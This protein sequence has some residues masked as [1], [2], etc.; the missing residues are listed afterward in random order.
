MG[1]T[2]KWQPVAVV[3]RG[4]ESVLAKVD[5]TL[6]TLWQ[7]QNIRPV[8]PASEVE[9]LRRV[10]LDLAGRTPTVTEVRHYLKDTDVNRY[11]K[12]VAKLL[13]SAD[14]ASHLATTWRTILIPEGVDLTVFGG[15]EAFDRW[16]AERLEAGDA[17]DSIVRKLLLAEG[18]LSTSGPLLFYSAAK[19]DPDR[20]AAQ[21]SRVFLGI[22]LECAQCH[23]HPFEPWKQTDFW[24]YAAF[25]A[26]I[27]RPQAE[28]ATV[29]T[30]MQVR[31]VDHGDVT[32][33]ESTQAVPPRLLG[34]SAIKM[35]LDPTA[36]RRQQLAD[37]LTSPEN[38]YFARA[39]VNRLWSLLFGRGIVDP[40]DD[41]GNKNPPISPELLDTL[42]SQLIESKFNLRRVLSTIALSRAYRL[43]SA[44]SANNNVDESQKRLRH[45]A[46]MEL[47]SLTAPQLYDCITVATLLQ[48]TGASTNMAFQLNRF[49]NTSRAE[50]IQQFASP[51]D[52]RIEFMA[53]IPQALTLMNG[54]L[55]DSATGMATSGLLKSLEAP[56]FTNDQRVEVLFL[57][58]LSRQPTDSE[59][60]MLRDAVP[61]NASLADRNEALADILW[62]LLNSAE[63]T[64][65]H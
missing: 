26:R 46:Q 6:A 34:E 5:Q 8:A 12:L 43:S 23:D 54:G 33:P 48:Q 58:T 16:L 3:S 44:A 41:F 55:I 15:R 19:L 20:L 49:G 40:V 59:W 51:V 37:W 39:T 27:S 32:L 50:F 31:D 9:L 38:P 10:Y 47:K 60:T 24:S 25:F 65:N 35:E 4:D 18:R 29:S 1:E 17:Y 57:A 28:L 7:D 11:P 36:V 42:A 45:F 62:A 21:T 14:H 2:T 61:T 63:F 13:A 52:N 64:L 53:G 30:V 56:F 22:R